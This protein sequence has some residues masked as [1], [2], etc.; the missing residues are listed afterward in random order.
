MVTYFIFDIIDE[1]EKLKDLLITC[2]DSGNQVYVE[3]EA[4]VGIRG[5]MRNWVFPCLID[6]K[7]SR[8]YLWVSEQMTVEKL[9]KSSLMNII[10]FA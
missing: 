3:L 4:K 5:N 1:I 6:R 10:H 9:K 2:T 8:F 7:A